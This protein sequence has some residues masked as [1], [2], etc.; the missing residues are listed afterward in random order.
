MTSDGGIKKHEE[1]KED[2]LKNYP[3]LGPED[4]FAFQCKSGL[5]CFTSCCGDIT[6]VLT[7]YDILR[8]K[9]RLGIGSEEFIDKYA[10]SPTIGQKNRMPIIVLRMNEDEKR[11]CQFL[12]HDGC[13]VYEDRP[14]AC[15]MYPVGVASRKSESNPEGEEFYFLIKDEEKCLGHDQ[16]VEWTIA[17]YLEDQEVAE[18][19][20]MNDLFKEL[21]IQ[22]IWQ[23]NDPVPAEQIQMFYMACYNLDLF[24]RFLTNSRFFEI[25]D[26]P[27]GTEEKIKE[28]DE[29]LLK[30]AFQWLKFSLF[31]VGSVRV[32]QDHMD[33][34]RAEIEADRKG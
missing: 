9:R 18:F 19:D 11:S 30:F 21:T 4:K 20:E 29:E 24:R 14:W 17:Q 22:P 5:P 12:G 33:K 6:I 13:K 1:M 3:R 32:K 23:Q 8:L 7:P 27:E 25:M 15:R 26:V 10:L 16:G 31:G 28:S 34:K 2:I